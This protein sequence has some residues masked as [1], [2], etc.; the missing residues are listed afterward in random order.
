MR[1]VSL[2]EVDN[3]E[4]AWR[5]ECV[6][7][8]NAYAR[9]DHVISAMLELVIAHQKKNLSAPSLITR[10]V[11]EKVVS[12]FPMA[13]PLTVSGQVQRPWMRDEHFRYDFADM[14]PDQA[15]APVR[16]RLPSTGQSMEMSFR[17]KHGQ[18]TH[19]K[20]DIFN[21][22]SHGDPFFPTFDGSGDITTGRTKFGL[23]H[24]R[25]TP[26]YKRQGF[27]QRVL[28]RGDERPELDYY[29]CDIFTQMYSDFE[30][31]INDSRTLRSIRMNDEGYELLPEDIEARFVTLLRSV[32]IF[33]QRHHIPTPVEG[34]AIV[35][36]VGSM[37]LRVLDRYGRP[38]GD[39]APNINHETRTHFEILDYN[40]D[41]SSI[42]R[43]FFRA[44]WTNFMRS[45]PDVSPV[46]EA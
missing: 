35:R 1:G 21:S 39:M 10:E 4:H 28:T 31:W 12:E 13:S 19:E 9:P 2:G 8:L 18:I 45:R 6:K 30:F 37:K 16:H 46:E 15:D 43:P 11:V 32:M 36:G 29:L 42:L 24:Y 17:Q 7:M 41:P 5:D 27:L 3:A 40:E 14:Y 23:Y 20:F 38:T 44:I 33:L 25:W 26:I 22:S 34:F